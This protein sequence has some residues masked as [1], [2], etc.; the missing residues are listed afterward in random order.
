MAKKSSS[1]AKNLVMVLF[2]VGA[3]G[4]V[5]M[6]MQ[7]R[8][9]I[10]Q[11]SQ[12]IDTL[13]DGKCEEAIK[14]FEKLL[15]TAKGEAVKRHKT[16]LAKCYVGL[17]EADGLS[18]AKQGEFYVKAAEYDESVLTDTTRRLV[19]MTRKKKAGPDAGSGDA[20][21]EK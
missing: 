20:A 18:V 4:F 1:M 8:A 19:E 9:L 21:E 5:W 17:A 15:G 13:S 10:K 3:G 6:K 12:A 2:I 16:N 7:K 11:E 14:L